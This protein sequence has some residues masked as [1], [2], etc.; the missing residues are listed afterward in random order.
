MLAEP[1]ALIDL[2]RSGEEVVL[3]EA[4]EPVVKVMKVTALSRAISPPVAGLRI[5][6][7]LQP[8]NPQADIAGRGPKAPT[9]AIK[10]WMEEAKALAASSAT[11][12]RGMTPDE[13][14]AKLR[15]ERRPLTEAEMESRRKWLDDVA[16]H[17][18]AASTGKT[19][20]TTEEIIDDLRSERC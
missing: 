13:I 1:K 8:G 19:G 16:R 4:G 6:E 9:G 5:E 17:A 3:T 2:A 20:S 18:A 11:G 12:K 10:A 7:A 15:A 14:V